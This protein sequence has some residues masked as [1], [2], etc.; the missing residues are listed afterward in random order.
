MSLSGPFPSSSE[1][2]V[3]AL[4]KPVCKKRHSYV[5]QSVL[6]ENCLYKGNSHIL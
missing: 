4:R 1:E 5:G 2:Y 3:T 6:Y